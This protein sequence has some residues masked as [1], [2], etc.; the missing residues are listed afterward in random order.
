[1]L[2]EYYINIEYWDEDNLPGESPPN[3]EA[4]APER[5]RTMKMSKVGRIV[6]VG[7]DKRRI[8]SY[9]SDG[10]IRH[11]Q[12]QLPESIFKLRGTALWADANH[13]NGVR[14]LSYILPPTSFP[15]M[16]ARYAL[17]LPS[18]PPSAQFLYK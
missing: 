8:S 18:L 5:D 4:C 15:V 12:R 1:M 10:C 17:S 6:E 13:L 11:S 2:F 3:Q 9:T 16:L 14:R 7:E